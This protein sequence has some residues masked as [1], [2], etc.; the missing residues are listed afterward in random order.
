MLRYSP[1]QCEYLEPLVMHFADCR[2]NEIGNNHRAV[3]VCIGFLVYTLLFGKI[4]GRCI[5]D[6]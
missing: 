4:S 6:L 5:L 2:R 3:G 1:I